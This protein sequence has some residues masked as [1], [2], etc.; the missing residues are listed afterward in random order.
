VNSYIIGQLAEIRRD[1]LIAAN[2]RRARARRRTRRR[3]RDDAKP[4]TLPSA[5]RSARATA[6]VRQPATCS[7]P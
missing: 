5:G 7:T 6:T 1:E 3:G 4:A 2:E